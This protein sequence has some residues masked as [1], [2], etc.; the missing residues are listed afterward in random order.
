M[1]LA[2]APLI[3]AIDLG[4]NSFRLEICK[5]E[6]GQLLRVEYLKDTVRLGAGLD[7]SGALDD[8]SMNRGL[9]SIAR[10]AE[11]VRGFD[12]RSV[13]AVAT[14]TL[15]EASNRDAFLSRAQALLGL[16]VDVISGREEARLIYGGVSHFLSGTQDRRLVFDIG[17]RSTELILGRGPMPD[18]VESYPVGSVEL[19]MRYFADGRLRASQFD[20]ARV[21]AEAELEGALGMLGSEKWDAAYGASGT[22]GAVSDVLKAEGMTDGAITAAALGELVRRLAD[23]G[24]VDRVN[25]AGLKDDRRAVIGGGV[26]IVQALSGL[27]QLDAIE[28]ARGALRH[29]VMVEMLAREAQAGDVRAV[30]VQ[31]LQRQFGADV[32]QAQ[33]VAEMAAWL[34]AALHPQSPDAPRRAAQK[35]RWAAALHEI[36]MAVSHEGYHRHGEYILRHADAAGFAEHQLE[37]LA[38][39][40][41]A[42]RGGLRKVEPQL[43][44]DALLRDQALTMR[45]AVVL[46]HARRD[47]APGNLRLAHSLAGWQFAVDTRW[48]HG[49]PQTMHLLRE[50]QRAWSRMPWPLDL[51]VD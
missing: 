47:P 42:Q 51:V 16:P 5:A 33:R 25:L 21:A 36:G 30:T 24:H 11:R 22:V 39:L 23:A 17:G 41:L 26:A 35:L 38:A 4:S 20:A 43:A 44:A 29:G 9:A 37:R 6:R 49:H 28:P 13:R 10:F 19:S 12:A 46:C 18:A 45:L 1:P 27:L 32:A 8:A 31:R 34:F 48:A 14:A 2:N 3:A 50:E 15:R 40:V 7:A